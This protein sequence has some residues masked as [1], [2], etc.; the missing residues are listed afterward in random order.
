MALV[1]GISGYYHDSAVALIRDGQILFAAQEERFTRLKHDASFPKKALTALLTYCNITLQDID[2]I[3]FYDKPFLKFERILETA[4]AVAPRG[5]SV[6]QKMMPIWVNEKLFLKHTLIGELREFDPNFSKDKIRFCEHHYS[7]AASAYFPSPFD[8]A[9]IVT[10][11]GVGEWATLSVATGKGGEIEIKKEILFPD[12]LGLLYSAVTYYLGFKVNSGEYKVMGLA[13]YGDP[14]YKDK[15]FDKVI[16]VKPDGSFRL[17]QRYFNYLS[18]LTMT[19]QNFE[20]LFGQP[21]RSSEEQVL[22]QFHM[23]IAS[24]MQA[25]VEDV[26]E[27]VV[28]N[29]FEENNS[30]NLCL[31]GGVA[32]NCVANGK[33]LEKSKFSNIWIQ[34]AAGDAGC[35]VGAAFAVYFD[36]TKSQKALN[37]QDLMQGALLGPSFSNAEIEEVLG[38]VG[39]VYSCLPTEKLVS[40]TAKLISQGN[41][42]GWFQGRMEFG[43]RALGSRS[44]LA[45]PRSATMQKTLNQKIKFRESFR[46]FAPAVAREDVQQWFDADVDS[47]YMLYVLKIAK[48][49]RKNEGHMTSAGFKKLEVIR[50]E[51]PAVIH[52]DMTAR[53]Q[54]VHKEH[55]LRFHALISEFRQ[56]T[57]CGLL[58]NTS[59]NVRGEPIVCTPLDA[60]KCFMGTDLDVLVIGDFLLMKDEQ[61]I[62]LSN[63]YQ[64][65]FAAD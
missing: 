8:D 37:G 11:D 9:V 38:S 52:V 2:F 32:L 35:S 53:V 19:N 28:D 46:P 10:I 56:I 25:V 61:D 18:G 26:V 1:L 59:F 23:D 4:V 27:K 50:S 45:D 21:R 39:C 22:T 40:R 30:R 58:V 6:F 14:I 47:P 31:A 3:A 43:P 20:K 12:S 42:I 60:I 49:K 16:D 5:F 29:A 7:H 63:N 41:A 34:P 55:N 17:N 57:G 51:I 13:P 54:T 62:A 15:F 33:L 24:S 48:E 44:I 36:E 65:S 64:R